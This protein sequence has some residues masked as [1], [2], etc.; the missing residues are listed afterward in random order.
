MK[1]LLVVDACIKRATSRTEKVANALVKEILAL[2]EY[3]E[4]RVI[5]ED[6]NIGHF[7]QKAIEIRDG[8]IARGEMDHPVF[9][10]ANQV[11][12]AD[13][14]VVAAPY[15]DFSYPTLLKE[16]V[17]SASA[18]NVCYKYDEHGISHGLS[19]AKALFYVSGA[20]GAVKDVDFGFWEFKALCGRFG[21]KKCKEV[22]IENLDI[23]GNDPQKIT[24]DVISTLSELVKK[25]LAD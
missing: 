4:V 5:L 7:D 11:K 21:I 1:T 16:W 3:E 22:L 12:D 20:G 14:V 15:W 6:E 10:Y 17:E 2:G 24:D 8:L 25:T 23:V 18:M 19:K 13:V 9:K